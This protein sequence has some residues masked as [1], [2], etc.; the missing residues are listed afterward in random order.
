M[1][2]ND[3]L[4]D[5][6]TD[7]A[8]AIRE[9]KGTT[10]KINPQEFS[11]IIRAFSITPYIYFA[12]P[13]VKRVLMANGVGDG[14][15]ITREQ[16]KEVEDIGEWF[17]NNAEITSFD[18][19]SVFEK[20]TNIN[21]KAFSYCSS[22]KR[23]DLKNVTSIRANAFDNCASLTSIDLRNVVTLGL[24]AVRNCNNLRGEILLEKCEGSLDGYTFQNAAITMVKAPLISTLHNSFNGCKQ[25]THA[26]IGDRLESITGTPFYQCHSLI[27][28]IIRSVTPP[29]I[30]SSGVFYDTN[31]CS[32]YVPDESVEAYKEVTNLSTYADRIKPLSEFN[33]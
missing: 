20:V 10:E 3:N 15:G 32:I 33:G 16:A 31:N 25:L 23:I 9:K 19:L 29:M 2:K 6:L 14:V 24:D 22:L 12:D 27:S 13:E 8:D 26:D 7:V 4:T 17:R 18:E 28:V 1:A 21:E 30:S 11:T 5:F